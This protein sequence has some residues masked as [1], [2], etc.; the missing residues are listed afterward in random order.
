MLRFLLVLYCRDTSDGVWTSWGIETKPFSDPAVTLP[1]NVALTDA[2]KQYTFTDPE[3]LLM[4][5]SANPGAW[6][7]DLSIEVKDI[8]SRDTS[9]FIVNIY[10]GA[11]TVAAET[12]TVT[13]HENIDGYGQQTQIEEIINRRSSRVRVKVNKSHYLYTSPPSDKVIITAVMPPQPCD[14]GINGGFSSAAARNAAIIGGVLPD[15]SSTGWEI[16]SDP[17]TTDA[18]VLINGGYTDPSVH[19]R[20]AVIAKSRNSFAVLDLG[21]QYQGANSSLRSEV[22]YRRQILNVDN[23]YAALCTSDIYIK[24]RYN[25]IHLYVPALGYVAGNMAK[26]DAL[27]GPWF[28]PSGALYGKIEDAE[29]LYVRY[30]QDDRDI[31]DEHQINFIVNIRGI[32]T[33]LFNDATLAS[34]KSAI[35]GIG[36][37]RLVSHVENLL[38]SACLRLVYSKAA[39]SLSLRRELL[40]IVDDILGPIKTAGGVYWYGAVCDTKNN[41]RELYANGDV[42][43]DVF[44]QP[45]ITAKRIHLNAIM[46]KSGEVAYSLGLV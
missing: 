4:F 30:D 8:T 37:R 27:F 38:S 28:P 29:G 44:M 26:N 24:D 43:L 42:A 25:N 13:I 41:P 18:K 45:T 6:G 5:A 17:E 16:F 40:A 36:P 19:N 12:Y 46:A 32:G 1:I 3:E 33:V 2:I 39:S 11:S 35:S 7:N 14:F 15:G 9:E 10:D 20:I 23:S 21:R 31:L 22:D 34:Q